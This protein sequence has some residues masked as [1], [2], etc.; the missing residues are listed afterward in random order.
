MLQQLSLLANPFSA[1]S[2][3][4]HVCHRMRW[5]RA[6]C[7]WKISHDAR[8]DFFR[9]RVEDTLDKWG[10]PKKANVPMPTEALPEQDRGS[11]PQV[12]VGNRGD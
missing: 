8:F 9:S 5:R 1:V 10:R 11:L 2:L 4:Q 12:E 3:H 7:E 6:K